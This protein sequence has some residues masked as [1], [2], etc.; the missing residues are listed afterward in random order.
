MRCIY[1]SQ[2]RQNHPPVNLQLVQLQIWFVFLGALLVQV[3]ISSNVTSWDEKLFDVLLVVISGQ[4]DQMISNLRTCNAMI[5]SA[6]LE[7]L[8]IVRGLP[9]QAQSNHPLPG[10]DR[11]PW[12]E[13]GVSHDGGAVF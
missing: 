5:P 12:S 6:H 4:A 3:D 11:Q 2:S 10:H 9:K 8:A 13:P 1:W 7:Q